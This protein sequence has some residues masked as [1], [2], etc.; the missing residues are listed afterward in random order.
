VLIPRE[1]GWFGAFANNSVASVVPLDEQPMYKYDWIGLRC[2]LPHKLRTLVTRSSTHYPM[3]M[4]F[5]GRGSMWGQDLARDRAAASLH[6]V[7]R[8]QRLR[9]PLLRTIL[10]PQ[11]PPHP[12]EQHHPQLDSFTLSLP[13]PSPS[14]SRSLSS[15]PLEPFTTPHSSNVLGRSCAAP[16]T[17]RAQLVAVVS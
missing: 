3:L 12:L 1:T 2:V 11:R 7:V 8:P 16:H 15:R 17:S 5:G 14:W 13:E 9:R 6:D 10:H 4:G